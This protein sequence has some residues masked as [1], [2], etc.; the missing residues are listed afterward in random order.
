MKDQLVNTLHKI[1]TTLVLNFKPRKTLPSLKKPTVQANLRITG[2]KKSFS[3]LM[4]KIPKKIQKISE[5]DFL[6]NF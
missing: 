4:K 6:V 5:L 2:K 3:S 1:I